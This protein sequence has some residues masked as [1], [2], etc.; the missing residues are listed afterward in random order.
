MH[1]G[2]TTAGLILTLVLGLRP[3][4]SSAQIR[5]TPT[6]F[7]PTFAYS[8]RLGVD[9]GGGGELSGLVTSLSGSWLGAQAKTHRRLGLAASLGLWNPKGPSGRTFVGGGSAQWLVNPGP[10]PTTFRIVGGASTVR[11]PGAF[12]SSVEGGLGAG[13]YWAQVPV[14]KLEVWAVGRVAGAESW[15]D[16]AWSWHPKISIGLTAGSKTAQA[17]SLGLRVAGECCE[18][19]VAVAAGLSR[20]F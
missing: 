2:R 17:H 19:G 5:G 11:Y 16:G 20:W 7:E 9:V 18:G 4:T 1:P 15:P 12:R 13:H 8:A 3:A 6:F 10:H 14:A